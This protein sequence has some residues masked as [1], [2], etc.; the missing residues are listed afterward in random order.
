MSRQPKSTVCI[1]IGTTGGLREVIPNRKMKA[2]RG[3][4]V[5]A[6]KN[7]FI[8]VGEYVLVNARRK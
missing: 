8:F 3:P 7:I 5:A 6:Q 2:Y 1:N 4:R